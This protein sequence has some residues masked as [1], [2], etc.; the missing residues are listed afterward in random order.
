MNQ[1]GRLRLVDQVI[2][3]LP[4]LVRQL[5]VRDTPGQLSGC[6]LG[7]RNGGGRN[8]LTLLSCDTPG[9]LLDGVHGLR[10][11]GRRNTLTL[12]SS[13]S[14][15]SPRAGSTPVLSLVGENVSS[16]GDEV[17]SFVVDVRMLGMGVETPPPPTSQLGAVLVAVKVGELVGSM[18][19]EVALGVV[20]GLVE[21]KTDGALEDIGL[22]GPRGTTLIKRKG[23]A[24]G[25]VVVV[26]P[27]VE[28]V[29]GL[30]LGQ[31]L[32][33]AVVVVI[34]PPFVENVV[35]LELGPTLGLGS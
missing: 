20:V 2:G 33:E 3:L 25:K 28:N 31:A 23:L 4:L 14:S 29:V 11:S 30:E 16:T 13:S 5:G 8:T 34:V 22:M 35:G 32:G 21:G 27:L 7:V 26:P 17:G 10:N 6:V 1:V 19:V 12:L 9:Q 24:L 15:S 18:V